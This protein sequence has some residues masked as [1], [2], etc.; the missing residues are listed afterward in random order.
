VDLTSAAFL[1]RLRRERQ[2]QNKPVIDL[3]A[4]SVFGSVLFTVT[5]H[6]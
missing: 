1:P 4:A 3:V 6:G 5:G 2:I